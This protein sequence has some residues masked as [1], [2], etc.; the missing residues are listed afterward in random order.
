MGYR[1]KEA[2]QATVPQ[3]W[4]LLSHICNVQKFFAWV[5]VLGRTCPCLSQ[6]CHLLRSAPGYHLMTSL[7]LGIIATPCIPL[8]ISLSCNPSGFVFLHFFQ[9]VGEFKHESQL[10]TQKWRD[11]NLTSQLYPHVV[12][13]HT[14]SLSHACSSARAVLLAHSKHCPPLTTSE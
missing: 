5:F 4:P 1:L 6:R 3:H 11:H 7:E 12:S 10:H 13:A 9:R 8:F 14:D 2:T